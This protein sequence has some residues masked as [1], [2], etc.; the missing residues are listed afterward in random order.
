M[1]AFA[2]VFHFFAHKF[3]SLRGRR[4]AFPGIFTGSFDCFLL[5]HSTIGYAAKFEVG[6]DKLGLSMRLA[7]RNPT[8]RCVRFHEVQQLLRVFATFS[9]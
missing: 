7:L 1:L 2:D 4:F 3:A 8:F 9:R 6:R 5:R